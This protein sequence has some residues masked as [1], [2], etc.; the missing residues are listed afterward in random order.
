[1]I[2]AAFVSLAELPLAANG[3]VDR[4]A[5]P[6]PVAIRPELNIPYT[7]PTNEPNPSSVG[8][9]AR[10]WTWTCRHPRQFLRSGGDSLSAMRVVTRIRNGLHAEVPFS[11]STK[12]QR[13]ARWQ[14]SSCALSRSHRD[15]KLPR[16][17]HA[18]ER[19]RSRCPLARNV[20]GF[21]NSSNRI[22]Q[23]SS[24]RWV[25]PPRITG[26]AALECAINEIVKRH[27]SLRTVF[28]SADGKPFQVILDTASISVPLVDLAPK[29]GKPLSGACRMCA[30]EAQRPFDLAG[31]PLLR[32]TI[33]RPTPSS[34]RSSW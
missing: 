11:S 25:S 27:E 33:V 19:I 32:A 28:D 26:C 16:S 20:C 29:P 31:E 30:D 5:L 34:S 21:S 14:G 15:N 2:P 23:M 18:R 24:C 3:K 4:A 8:S 1:M 12:R 22:P 17:S 9:G 6:A 10:F 13:L 7:A